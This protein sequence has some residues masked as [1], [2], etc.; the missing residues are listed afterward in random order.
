MD[1]TR[2]EEERHDGWQYETEPAY[3]VN[4]WSK[5][6]A[7]RLRGPV[8]ERDEDFEWTGI[9]NPSENMVEVVMI[10]DD[11]IHVVDKDDLQL[12]DELAYCSECGQV[13]CGHDGREREG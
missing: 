13:G 10:G 4:G 7:F 1:I 12:L 2:S 6:I 3:T 9:E 5:G 11:A 8:M